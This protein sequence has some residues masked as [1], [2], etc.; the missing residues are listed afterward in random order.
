MLQLAMI[1]RENIEQ[2]PQGQENALGGLYN[3]DGQRYFGPLDDQP[4]ETNPGEWAS[5]WRRSSR[6]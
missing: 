4:W 3:P 6:A 2:L 5:S 1:K